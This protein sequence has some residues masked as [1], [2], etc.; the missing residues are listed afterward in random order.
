MPIAHAP[1]RHISLPGSRSIRNNTLYAVSV[2][3]HFLSRKTLRRMYVVFR[4]SIFKYN[5]I[6]YAFQRIVTVV[7]PFLTISH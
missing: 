1:I 3:E 7:M 6:E 2:I 4:N 5:V